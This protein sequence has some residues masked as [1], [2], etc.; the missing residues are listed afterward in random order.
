MKVALSRLALHAPRS[1]DHDHLL[2]SA[3]P[4][5]SRLIHVEDPIPTCIALDDVLYV[6]VEELP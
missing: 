3:L 2:L 5:E 4:G 6:L 1:L